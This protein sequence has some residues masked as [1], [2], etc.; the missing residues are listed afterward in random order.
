[1]PELDVAQ[2]TDKSSRD[3]E[4]VRLYR[5][6]DFLTAYSIHTD[7]RVKEDPHQ[8]IGGLWEEYGILQRDF[9]IAQGLKPHHRLLDVGC[10]T[11]RLARTIVPYLES[12]KYVGVDISAEA[13]V[14]AIWVSR[15]EGWQDKA[16][17][18]I[19]VVAAWP[20]MEPVDFVWAFSVFI[21]LPSEIVSLMMSDVAGCLA[22]RG[23]FLFS[24]VPTDLPDN[25]RTGLKQFKHPLSFYEG[26]A[27]GLGYSLSEVEWPGRQRILAMEKT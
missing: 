15:V 5:D 7:L 8:A 26:V 2:F 20:V 13:L 27:H 21:H 19:S 23:K 22:P 12:W 1:M 3:P 25:T 18:F 11:G 9:L 14:Y 6:H 17:R 4:V 10:G 16:P 24:Y